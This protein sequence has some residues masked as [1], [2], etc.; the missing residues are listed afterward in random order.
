V[1]K[2]AIFRVRGHTGWGVFSAFIL[3]VALVEEGLLGGSD[4]LTF[5]SFRK[6]IKG[7]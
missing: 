5:I 3:G 1:Y 7:V 2:T 4:V 6:W